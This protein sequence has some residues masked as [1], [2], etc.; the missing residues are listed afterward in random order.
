MTN[1][2]TKRKADDDTGCGSTKRTKTR[3]PPRGSE[4]VAKQVT[5]FMDLPQELRDIV[6]HELWLQSGTVIKEKHSHVALNE[7]VQIYYGNEPTRPFTG[8]PQLAFPYFI[9]YLEEY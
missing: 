3:E 2:I 9:P 7:K 8:L 5:R 1:S 4:S 6:Y